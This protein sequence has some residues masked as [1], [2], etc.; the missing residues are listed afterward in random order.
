MKMLCA[1]KKAIKFFCS[2][3]ALCVLITAL[4]CGKT[5]FAAAP[6]SLDQVNSFLFSSVSNDARNR[7]LIET[8]QPD[9]IHRDIFEWIGTHFSDIGWQG[10]TNT[11]QELKN[12]SLVMGGISGQYW[13]PDYESGP[14]TVDQ[15]TKNA[16]SIQDDWT[17]T[18]NYKRLNLQNPTAIDQLIYKAKKQ[19]D[20]GV[21][22]IEFDEYGGQ[23][24]DY[25]Y[26]KSSLATI[27]S[28]LKSYVMT[29]YG[30]TIYMHKFCCRRTGFSRFYRFN[31]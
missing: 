11:I 31:K 28:S 15:A 4:P 22:G 5:V 19:I 6:T 27:A 17:K 14:A 30:R 7:R 23:T 10:A 16:C 18:I 13:A 8:I 3:L 21:D 25:D 29:T 20:A 26:V 12:N 2:L 24:G 1:S 9:L